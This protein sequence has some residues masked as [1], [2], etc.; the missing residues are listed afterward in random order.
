MSRRIL[1]VPVNHGAGVTVACLGLVHALSRR[2]VSVGFAKPFAQARGTAADRSTDLFRLATSLRPPQPIEAAD[3]ENNLA[4]GRTHS[5]MVRVVEQI[6][7]L[8]TDHKVLVLE[9]LVPTPEQPYANLVN[10][11]VARA[12]DAGVLLVAAVRDLD[13]TRFAEKAAA[14]ARIYHTSGQ[15]RVIGVVANHV[16]DDVDPGLLGD[17]LRTHDLP[18]V[19][20]IRDHAE[21]LESRVSDLV[22]E[23]GL[24]VLTG[25]LDRRVAFTVIAAQPVP[26]FL[27]F[28]QD[29]ALV[30]APGDRHDVLMSTALAEAAGRRPAGLLLTV[31]IRPDPDVMELVRP[32][33]ATG[34][35]V[36]LTP[37]L[38][39]PAA[40]RIVGRDRD[41]PE[42][43][44]ARGRRVMEVVA[45]SYDPAFLEGLPREV[46]PHRTTPAQ[47][48]ARLREQMAKGHIHL[49]VTDATD[50]RVLRALQLL[51][52]Q[53]SLRF[54]VLADP[55]EL[56]EGMAL[57]G[58]SLPVNIRVVDPA[59]QTAEVTA[60]R[61]QI[62]A[63]GGKV[64]GDALLHALVLLRQGEVD[65][66]VG[67]LTE[68]RAV[69]LSALRQV[70]PLAA[71]APVASTTQAVLLPDAV[72]FVADTMLNI[73]PDAEAL[74][75]I[76]AQTAATAELSG[77]TPHVAFIAPSSSSPHADHAREAIRVA[78]EYLAEHRPDLETCG[79][80]PF[81]QA[82]APEHAG[83]G[84]ATICVFPDIDSAGA[85]AKA[86]AQSG[87]VRVHPP[88]LQGLTKAVNMLPADA[89]ID[90]VMDLLVATAV[91][92]A[93]LT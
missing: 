90:V 49:A 7:E 12:L 42:D 20:F 5:A 67:G 77:V 47:F 79:P 27:E 48:A 88:V 41:I 68:D 38:T 46:R 93:D 64:P 84:G 80:I 63:A 39:F 15:K 31:G 16:P 53:E 65:G 85:T 3:L 30:V 58:D 74:A 78:R 40:T 44:E 73:Q 8:D 71:E 37:D 2:H 91:Q 86:M 17:I 43:D 51:Q 59:T 1:V 54:T 4:L 29:G 87:G 26:G 69:F 35:P 55:A 36:L 34:L 24:E 57:L 18:C 13:P 45:E 82:S 6:A 83:T 50:H 11:D 22:R 75:A 76:A 21:F 52:R 66:L 14:V 70:V 92:A 61:E 32:A 72:L 23:L 60:L 62:A 25:D 56:D 19:A 9:G 33:L 28:L 89:D 81:R 10:V